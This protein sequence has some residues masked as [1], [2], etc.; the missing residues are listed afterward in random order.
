MKKIRIRSSFETERKEVNATKIKD[1]EPLLIE[2]GLSKAEFARMMNTSSQNIQNWCNRGVPAIKAFEAASKLGIPVSDLIHLSE[3]REDN[4]SPKELAERSRERRD[5]LR[6]LMAKKARYQAPPEF[7]NKNFKKTEV[8]T[9]R[10]VLFEIIESGL[11]K[12]L[13]QKEL[14]KLISMLESLPSG[15]VDSEDKD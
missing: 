10:E 1:L 9:A 12:G 3:D 5:E 8:L 11:L 13:S 14:F 2:R 4:F 15:S 6:D 7:I